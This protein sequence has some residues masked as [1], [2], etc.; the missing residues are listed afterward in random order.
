[1]KYQWTLQTTAS[2]KEFAC[3]AGDPGS[4]PGSGRS[5]GEGNGYP[6]QCSFLENSMDREDPG[7]LLQSTGLQRVQLDSAT[8][9]FHFLQTTGKVESM[10]HD[11]TLTI[12]LEYIEFNWRRA[13]QP[14]PVFFP[15]ESHRQKTLVGYSA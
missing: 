1:M 15:G 5:P 13:W 10:K 3:N 2:G 7:G 11:K 6:F 14:T 12:Y 4:I 8:F 9:H